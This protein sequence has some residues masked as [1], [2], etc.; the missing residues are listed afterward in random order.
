MSTILLDKLLE[1]SSIAV[2]GASARDGSPGYKLTQ[3]LLHG[4]YKGSLFLVNP[5]YDSIF[6]Q[7][8]YKSVKRLPQVPDLAIIIVPPRLLRRTLAQCARV[9]IRLAVVMSGTTGSVALHRYARRLGMRLMGPWCAGLIRPHIGLNATYSKNRISAGDLAIISQSAS[10]CAAMVDWAET[11][12]VGFSAMLSTGL[13][14]DISLPDLV[15]LLAEDWRSRA[16]IV[17]VDHIN[18]SR[19]FLSAL[20]AAARIKPVVLMRSSDEGIQYCDALTRTGQVYNSDDVFQAALNRAG[21]VR[22]R[23]FSNLHAAARILS[24]RIRVKGNRVAIVSNANAPALM[25]LGRM[26]EKGFLAPPVN[27]TLRVQFEKKHQLG[28]SSDNPFIL[29]KP[30]K[31]T[32]HYQVCIKAL[33]QASE[34]DAVLVIFVPDSRNDANAIAQAI[35]ECQPF[36]KPLITCWMGDAS[37][38]EALKTLSHAGIPNFRTPEEATDGFDFLHRYFIS[39]QQL[40]QFPNPV[41]RNTPADTTT[42]GALVTQELSAG[43][44]VLGPM[45]TRAL[46]ELFDIPVLPSQRATNMVD[47]IAMARSIGFPVAMKLVS[48]NISYKASVVS[49]Q[50]NI[51]SDSDVERAWQLIELRLRRSRPD[52]IFNGVLIEAMHTP[53]NARHMALSISRDANFGPV[54]SLGIGGELTALVHRR[55]VQLPPLNRFLIDDMLDDA[56]F[57]TYLGPFRHTLAVSPSPLKPILRRISELACELP[58]VFSLDINPLV[59]SEQ[60]AMAIDVHITLENPA[61]DTRYKHLAIH[62]YPWHWIRDVTL[63][64]KSIVQ[65]RPIRPEDASALQEMVRN[66]SAQARYFRFMHAVNELSLQMMAQFTKLDYDRQMAFIATS[67]TIDTTRPASANETKQRV[68]GASRYTISSHRQSAEFA[69]SVIDDCA[70]KGLATQLMRILMEH[71]RSQGLKTLFGDVLRSNTPMQALMNSLGFKG[72]PSRDDNDV[73]VYTCDLGEATSL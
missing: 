42:A 27:A 9:G 20:S 51:N 57:H 35:I 65:L 40:L 17:Y 36:I 49:T 52:A 32:E 47:A 71:A 11:S 2:I 10:L 45:K 14:T 58:E 64:D 4:S 60:G 5:R 12:N 33:L 22:I 8:C 41:S 54:I 56:D 23:G 46:M 16:I 43:V 34:F 62:P 7:S 69:V 44:R 68:L 55:R 3:N 13:D 48:P 37:V 73:I 38:H 19:T 39:Q 70:G 18:K 30:T 26:R 31:L 21:V 61:S 66:M 6:E 63:K 67:D 28:F 53:Q 15:D 24:R 1:P 59:I 25:V 50:L 29:R 72:V